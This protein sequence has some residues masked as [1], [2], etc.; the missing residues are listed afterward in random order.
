M[1]GDGERMGIKYIDEVAGEISRIVLLLIVVR[2]AISSGTL[3][4]AKPD[5]PRIVVSPW[6]VGRYAHI[7]AHARRA[8]I[9]S[10]EPA[11]EAA[12]PRF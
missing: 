4:P 10:L 3:P 2:R 11:A 5:G 6:M 12:T 1:P 7:R 8:V 9:A